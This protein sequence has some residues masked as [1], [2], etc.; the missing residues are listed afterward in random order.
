MDQLDHVRW[1]CNEKTSHNLLYCFP[2][3]VCIRVYKV[4]I[5]FRMIFLGTYDINDCPCKGTQ[6]MSC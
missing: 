1:S 6:Y 3:G 5:Y 4:D 2:S